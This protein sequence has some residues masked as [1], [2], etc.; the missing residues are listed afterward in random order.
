MK[1]GCGYDNVQ[2]VLRMYVPFEVDIEKII[3][4]VDEKAL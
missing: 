3:K 4:S 2:S 1:D